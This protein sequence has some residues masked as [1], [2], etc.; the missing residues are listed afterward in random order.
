MKQYFIL[1][2]SFIL[3]N[4]TKSMKKITRFIIFFLI[5]MGCNRPWYK[6]MHQVR[7]G[8]YID[9]ES[10]DMCLRYFTIDESGNK[11][12]RIHLSSLCILF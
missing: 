6:R 10:G 9:K 3:L 7:D 4:S 2:V 12:K 8:L 11:K 1:N 5:L